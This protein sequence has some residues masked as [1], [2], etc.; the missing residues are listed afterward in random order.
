MKGRSKWGF[1]K[2]KNHLYILETS[3]IET[4]MLTLEVYLC[5]HK[6]VF[7]LTLEKDWAN[8]YGLKYT[9]Y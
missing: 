7:H 1:I 5:D 6:S 2:L 3:E 9:A 4:G 8:E